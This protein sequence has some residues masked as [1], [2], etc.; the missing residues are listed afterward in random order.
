MSGKDLVFETVH[1]GTDA[2]TYAERIPGLDIIVLSL[3]LRDVH[4][5]TER[6]NLASFDRAYGYLKGILKKS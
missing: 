2:G 6:L 5:P 1:Y 4:T 3:E